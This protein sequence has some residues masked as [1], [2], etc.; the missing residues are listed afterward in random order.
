MLVVSDS[1]GG[2][3]RTAGGSWGFLS[4]GCSMRTRSSAFSLPSRVES[5]S[6]MVSSDVCFCGSMSSSLS[7]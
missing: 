2:R 4:I 1:R 3:G 6:G 7:N 5:S